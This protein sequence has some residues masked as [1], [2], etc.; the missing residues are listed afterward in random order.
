MRNARGFTLVELMIVV[1]VIG[2]L[3]AIATP[4]MTGMRLRAREAAVRE[5][6]HT[7][8]VATEDFSVTNSGLYPANIADVSRSGHTLVD[9]LPGSQLLQ[10]PFTSIRSEPIDGASATAGQVGYAPALDGSGT[11]TGYTIT[12]FGHSNEIVHWDQT[13]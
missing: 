9:M 1:V 5:N 11:P 13:H 3:A 8:Q 12:G 6:C 2:I 4:N 7:V 10:N